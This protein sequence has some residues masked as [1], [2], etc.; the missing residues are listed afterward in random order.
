MLVVLVATGVLGAGVLG[1]GVA[2]GVL[3]V[4]GRPVRNGQGS[5]GEHPRR[6]CSEHVASLR[7]GKDREQSPNLALDLQP[8]EPMI[9][10]QFL[11]HRQCYLGTPLNLSFLF[12]CV[13][14]S[15]SI[16]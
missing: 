16:E 2:R 4:A 5:T 6:T 11:C 9:H 13:H 14:Y 8:L 15:K 10:R 3:G 1:A 12:P 7:N